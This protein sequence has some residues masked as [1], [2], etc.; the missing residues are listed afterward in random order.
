LSDLDSSVLRLA[1]KN[2]NVIRRALQDV[3]QV[4]VAELMGLSQPTLSEWKNA[5]LSRITAM[6]AASG[7]RVVPCSARFYSEEHIT[8][9][10]TLARQGLEAGSQEEFE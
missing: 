5:H 6:L 7:L 9:L 10:K 1:Q 4:R 3:G 2:D 8:A